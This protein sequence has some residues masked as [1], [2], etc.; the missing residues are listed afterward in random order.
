MYVQ[1][2][3]ERTLFVH[4]T[5]CFL[6]SS[7][8]NSRR[9]AASLPLTRLGVCSRVRA[10]L[11]SLVR[12]SAQAIHATELSSSINPI[13]SQL[14]PFTP[15][16]FSIPRESSASI[17]L[18]E[19]QLAALTIQS[20]RVQLRASSRFPYHL[21]SYSHDRSCSPDSMPARKDPWAYAR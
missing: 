2:V 17:N 8:T 1:L 18:S 13:C 4:K 19:K 11:Q 12:C 20:C 16:S 7:S 10:S 14:E 15:D 9:L 6:E 3:K 5:F 21:H